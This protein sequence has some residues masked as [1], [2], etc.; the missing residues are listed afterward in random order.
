MATIVKKRCTRPG[1]NKEY[2]DAENNPTAC[3]YHNGKVI[4]HDTKKGWTCCNQVVY[5]FDDFQKIA[6][7]CTAAHTDI[8]ENDPTF[9]KSNTVANAAKGILQMKINVKSD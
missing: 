4:F 1:C 8:R 2:T 6:G 5:D 3:K 9:F 7:C